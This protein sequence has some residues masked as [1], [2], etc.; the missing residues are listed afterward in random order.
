M[1]VMMNYESNTFGMDVII[2]IISQDEP[3]MLAENDENPVKK[4]NESFIQEMATRESEADYFLSIFYDQSVERRYTNIN[5]VCHI[6]E[7]DSAI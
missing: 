4:L 7:I 5:N 6:K 1:H 3:Y 2:A